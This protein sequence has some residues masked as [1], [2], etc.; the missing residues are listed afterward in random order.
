[1]K[2]LIKIMFTAVLLLSLLVSVTGC[3]QSDPGTPPPE[4]LN[5][6]GEASETSA[7]SAEILQG[8]VT[9][10]VGRDGRVAWPVD[11]YDNAAVHTMLNYV[12]GDMLFPTYTYEEEEGFVA[13]H[14]QG[15]YTRDDETLISDL[16]V[17]DLVLFSGGQL[18]LY[19]KDIPSANITATP[20]GHFN[21]VEGEN[22]TDTIINAY[23]SNQGDVWGVDVYFWI[24]NNL[25]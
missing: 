17:G 23:V 10:R 16:H 22:L 19:F 15:S 12:S 3:A 14:I 4:V 2:N 25:R 7:Y 1:M 18:R 21:E 6:D 5:P 8:A 20:V 13:H 9:V 24:T 11:M